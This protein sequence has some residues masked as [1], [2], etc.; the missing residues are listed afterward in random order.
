MR[1]KLAFLYSK[2]TSVVLFIGF[3]ILNLYFFIK[4]FCI[5][6]FNV[7]SNADEYYENNLYSISNISIDKI[8]YTPSQPYVFLSSLVNSLINSPKIAVRFVS[9]ISC[10]FLLFYFI[11]RIKINRCVEEDILLERT[12]GLS[13]F[14]CAIFITN[15]MFIGTSDFLSVV[16]LVFAL[17]HILKSI[18]SGKIELSNKKSIVVGVLLALAVATRPTAMVLI[19]SF[20]FSILVILGFQNIFI[21]QNYLIG[22]TGLLVFIIINIFPVIE[23]STVILDVKEV[24]KETGVNW[25]QRNYLMAKFWDEGKIPNT[26]WIGTIEVIN[27]KKENPDFVFPKNQF[28]LMVKEPGLFFRQLSR[29]FI[30]GLYTS[31]RYMYLLFPLMFLAF[32]KKNKYLN[33]IQ[34]SKSE[35]SNSESRNRVLVVFHL[36]SIVLFSFLAIKLLEFRWLIPSLILYTFF[37]INYLSN[38]SKNVRFLIYNASFLS[39]IVL[40]LWFFIKEGL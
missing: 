39:G 34:I 4:N 20:Y 24:P 1:D 40:Y 12:Y 11:K 35:T 26:Q 8:F 31:C 27:Y 15:Q 30:K 38:F 17:F 25:F 3:V 6:F 7:G 13:F 37:S 22:F 14:V 19:M 36:T 18:N 21:K 10:V 2:K 9:L 28:D 23:Q 16:F 29:M 33:I 32:I 5:I